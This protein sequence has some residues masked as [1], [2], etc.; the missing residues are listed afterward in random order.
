MYI[1]YTYQAISKLKK[2]T[3]KRNGFNY[4]KNDKNILDFR[5]FKNKTKNFNDCLFLLKYKKRQKAFTSFSF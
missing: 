2:K 4:T 5:R 3:N 1:N